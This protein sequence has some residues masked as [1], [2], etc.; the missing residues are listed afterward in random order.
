MSSTSRSHSPNILIYLEVENK[1]IRLSDILYQSA[2]LHEEAEVPPQTEASLVF[3]IDGN[4]EREEVIL[5]KGI[6][7]GDNLVI[8]SYSDPLRLN[9]RKL[10]V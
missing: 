7:K 2:T 1:K 10:P 4:E 3:S 6:S 9:G 8:F 5:H